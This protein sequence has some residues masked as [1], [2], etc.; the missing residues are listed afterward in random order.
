MGSRLGSQPDRHG[1]DLALIA[2]GYEVGG[3]CE[4]DPFAR[5]V[6]EARFLATLARQ[7]WAA[8]V[9]CPPGWK[10]G[11][12]LLGPTD[13]RNLDGFCADPAVRVVDNA[14]PGSVFAGKSVRFSQRV[15]RRP[16]E[17]R[18]VDAALGSGQVEAEPRHDS[19]G[20][21]FWFASDIREVRAADVPDA[22][23][24]CGGPPWQHETPE[25]QE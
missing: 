9:S 14:D 10:A 1:F 23:L 16:D 4:I 12:R 7:A 19:D 15:G 22:D 6:S 24:W 5:R 2:A 8:A 18:M 20:S 25:A 21:T 3:A 13:S 17:S 11:S